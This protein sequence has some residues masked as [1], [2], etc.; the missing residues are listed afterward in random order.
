MTA[1]TAIA[2]LPAVTS[3]ASLEALRQK[4]VED[5]AREFEAL[6]LAQMIGAMRKTVGD[7][8]LLQ[9]SPE[10]KLLD[11]FF[12][13][14]LARSLVDDVELGLARQLAGEVERRHGVAV[15]GLDAAAETRDSADGTATAPGAAHDAAAARDA[16]RAWS[17]EFAAHGERL[18][19]PVAARVSSAY[20]A[21]RDPL[22]GE[23]AFHAGID[24][25]APRGT[26]V[27][28]AADGEV[29]FSGRAGD[30]GN[31][32]EL[33]HRDGTRTRYA[34]LES[35]DVRAGDVVRAGE[36]IGAVGSSGRTTGAHLHFVVERQGRVIDPGPLLF[37][38]EA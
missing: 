31:L 2:A 6:L 35:S 33:R 37:R 34:H 23:A 9:A 1:A 25:A 5:V 7:S 16:L 32:V 18:L 27:R 8:G 29:V 19:A 20:G 15:E 4:P 13:L 24:L 22:T 36:V 38:T 14:E 26:P 30:A 21:R 17:D 10:R 12:D 11:G 28:A 3:D